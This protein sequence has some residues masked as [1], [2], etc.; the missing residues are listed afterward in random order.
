M[1][2]PRPLPE[3][4]PACRALPWGEVVAME[5]GRRAAF[6]QSKNTRNGQRAEFNIKEQKA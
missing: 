5:A 1:A 3:P 4:D 2:L 6:A